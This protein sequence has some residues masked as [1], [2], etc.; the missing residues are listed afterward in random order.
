MSNA[1]SSLIKGIAFALTVFCFSTQISS[2]QIGIGTTSPEG[3]IDVTG[4]NSGLLFPRVALSSTQDLTT[5]VN[6]NGGN[7][8]AGTT[9]F[10]TNNS[11][12]G[13]NDVQ[14]GVYTF[15]GT[16][17]QP[18]FSRED[19]ALYKQTGGCFRAPIQS[20]ALE[21]ATA[22]RLE[23]LDGAVFTPKYSGMYRIEVK[24]N[25]GAGKI[26]DFT[27]GSESY[28]SLAT[29]EGAFFFKLEGN[30][31]IMIDPEST[32]YDY[33]QGWSYTHAYSAESDN[34]PS[35]RST[36][37]YNV[38]HYA[39]LVYYKP[40]IAGIPYTFNLSHKAVTGAAVFQN[41][42]AS[43]EGMG[44]VGHDVPCSVEFEFLGN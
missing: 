35:G 15:D 20:G 24:T 28:I 4:S 38:P 21:Y 10:N 42:G 37:S 13:A 41:A 17:W 23:S 5:V 16:R 43:G 31:R 19:Y 25:F 12:L 14:V 33:E 34:D 1:F 32:T 6:P 30:G 7:L 8:A 11:A 26:E 44:H 39:T 2:A 9:V 36:E 3:A 22:S 18:Q 29:S 27:T 40:L